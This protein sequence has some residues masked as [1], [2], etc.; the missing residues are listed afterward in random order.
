MGKWS[1]Q[2]TGFLIRMATWRSVTF[3]P[4]PPFSVREKG[5]RQ[6]GIDGLKTGRMSSGPQTKE[7]PLYV[8]PSILESEAWQRVVCVLR[9][10]DPGQISSMRFLETS[11]QD[12][13]TATKLVT[14]TAIQLLFRREKEGKRLTVPSGGS[15]LSCEVPKSV[16]LWLLKQIPIWWLFF[17]LKALSM[18]W[19][20]KVNCNCSKTIISSWG[21]GRG[22]AVI[23]TGTHQNKMHALHTL[24][25]FRFLAV[26]SWKQL[27]RELEI[28]LGRDHT[29]Y[30]VHCSGHWPYFSPPQLCLTEQ[31]TA[32]A[33]GKSEDKVFSL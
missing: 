6:N 31:Q 11:P 22:L 24:F 4:T 9:Y 2:Q 10:E 30:S 25:S 19:S 23:S 26:S 13:N 7:P 32:S 15:T 29:H 3:L 8:C 18:T 33:K 21:A 12:R 14:N 28:A 16:I 27:N 20:Q 5:R 1:W 17:L